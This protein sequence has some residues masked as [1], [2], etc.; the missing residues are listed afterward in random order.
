MEM[1]REKVVRI[2]EGEDIGAK[3]NLN[4]FIE[5]NEFDNDVIMD[6]QAMGVGDIYCGG[7]GAWAQ[8]AVMRV[9]G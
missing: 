8:W 6:L 4:E 2:I 9:R 7:G 3:V 5:V 1:Q